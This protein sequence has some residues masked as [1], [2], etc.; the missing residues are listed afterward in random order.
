MNIVLSAARK[1][2]KDLVAHLQFQV[3]ELTR[4]KNELKRANEV[5]RVQL[6]MLAETNRTLL[7]NQIANGG[8]GSATAGALGLG[9]ALGSA[10][11]GALGLGGPAGLPGNN[12]GHPAALVDQLTM[13]RIAAQSR[14]QA[15]QQRGLGPIS[16]GAVTGKHNGNLESLNSKGFPR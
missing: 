6:D 12:T 11:L 14:L 2:N 4:E 13:E 9:G 3:E 10:S 1:R 7:L 16:S 15:M 8:G 5:M